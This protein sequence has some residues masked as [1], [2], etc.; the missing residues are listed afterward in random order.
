MKQYHWDFEEYFLFDYESLTNEER[1]KFVPEYDK[2]V[3]CDSVNNSK[4]ADIFYSKWETYKVFRE[5]F[6]RDA[7]LVKGLADTDSDNVNEFVKKHQSF[8]M[9]PIN[10]ACGKGIQLVRASSIEEAKNKLENVLKELNTPY[11]VEELIVQ[12]QDM[13]KLHPNSVNTI[14]ITT[15][16]YGDEIEIIH[17]F[18]RTG[19][20]GNFV[21]NGG[22][23][24]I[25]AAI[26]PNEGRVIAAID[27]LNH[28]YTEHPNSH[29]QLVGFMIPK[30]NEAIS[31]AKKLASVLPDIKYVGW[32]LALTENGWVIVEGND[33][34]AFIG[35]QLPIHKGFKPELDLIKKKLLNN[36]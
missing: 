10:A 3:F 13:A 24:G 19:Q 25:I 21:D 1:L 7:I 2:N 35:F 18:M 9:K 8:I 6:K 32:D 28:E 12:S 14:R 20:G 15:I 27:E 34:G 5:F 17:P 33:K 29:E 22:S 23:G 36:I 11:I 4:Q 16:N 30:W 26:N 31:F